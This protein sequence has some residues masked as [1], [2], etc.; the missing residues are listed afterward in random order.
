LSLRRPEEI[1]AVAVFLASDRRA[2]SRHRH[3]DGRASRQRSSREM[4]YRTCAIFCRQ[5][6]R[7]GGLK[8][9][10]A[11]VIQSS[12]DRKSRP[13][14]Q[15]GR[16]GA[17]F[18]KPKGL[19]DPVLATCSVRLAASPRDGARQAQITRGAARSETPGF[20]QGPGLPRISGRARAP[21]SRSEASDAYGAEGNFGRPCQEWCGREGKSTCRACRFKPAG[22]KTR[23][24]SSSGMT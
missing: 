14:A 3:L 1:A 21:G 7:A 6:E 4:R 5:L 10:R 2:T 9:V 15:G 11:E 24:R 22:P 17:A 8:R 23:A 16:S 18:E 20:P 12:N 13:R 19:R